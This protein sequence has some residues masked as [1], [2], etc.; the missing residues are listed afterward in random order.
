MEYK[1]QNCQTEKNN[2]KTSQLL[3][4][5]KQLENLSNRNMRAYRFVKM[6]NCE[7]KVLKLGYKV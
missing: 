2:W 1:S 4:W 3:N 5:E 6:S 7:W